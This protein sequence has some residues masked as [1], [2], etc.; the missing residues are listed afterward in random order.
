MADDSR[1][2][3]HPRPV[4]FA[5][6]FSNNAIELQL[7]FWVQNVKEWALVKGAI[8]TA[9]D[10]AFKESGIKLAMQQQ[11]LFLHNAKE[12]D[13]DQEQQFAAG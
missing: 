10:V 8:I 6:D 1:I 7:L 12:T 11:E 5:K 3:K 4:V 2:M 13:T 9:I